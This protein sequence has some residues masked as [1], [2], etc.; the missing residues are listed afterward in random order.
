MLDLYCRAKPYEIVPGDGRFIG[1]VD[2]NDTALN[3]ALPSR[4]RHDN[5]SYQRQQIILVDG[6]RG[7]LQGRFCP[8]PNL[9]YPSAVSAGSWIYQPDT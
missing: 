1:G 5:S 6:K 8:Y 7:C 2:D 4:T 9:L 3:V